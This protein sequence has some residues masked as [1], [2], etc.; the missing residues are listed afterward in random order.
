MA[1]AVCLL[2]DQRGDRAV[3][4]LWDRLE[5]VGIPTLRS[6]THGRHHAHLSYTV[7]ASWDL[8]AVQNAVAALGDHGEVTLHFQAVATFPR[9][10]VCLVPA[11]FPDL[12]ERQRAVNEAV[13][14][15]GAVI[16]RHYQTG[17][18]LPHCSL[19]PRARLAQLPNIT[20]LVND[21]LPLTVR[22]TR[23]AL[24]DSGTGQVWPLP[25]VP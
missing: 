17:I 25:N 4:G 24:I 23:A 14:A 12:M 18:W 1:L 6:H 7:L 15:T 13:A 16:H 5:T 21:V 9:G 19:A 22:A 20:A 3:R 11:I 2:F 8:E 10:R